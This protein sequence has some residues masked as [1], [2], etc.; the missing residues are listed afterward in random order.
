MCS[1]AGISAVHPGTGKTITVVNLLSQDGIRMMLNKAVTNFSGFAPLGMVLVAVIGSGAAEKSG[2]LA[3]LMHKVLA[4]APP[5]VVT[6][7]ILFVGINGNIAGDSAFV[8]M[9][10]LSA[11]VFLS[12]STS[13]K[14]NWI[15]KARW[16]VD[17]KFYTSSGVSAGMDMALGFISDQYGL[18]SA[19]QIALDIEYL[20]NDDKDEDIFSTVVS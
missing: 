16:V 8:I 9:P 15:Q 17:G 10:P 4:S 3:V 20:W 12:M 6:F 7:A 14:V 1:A 18:A 2:F 11:I 5:A 19:K 13:N